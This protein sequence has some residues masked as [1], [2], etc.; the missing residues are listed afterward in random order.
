MPITKDAATTIEGYPF[1]CGHCGI[2][3]NIPEDEGC[4]PLYNLLDIITDHTS[5]LVYSKETVIE[6]KKIVSFFQEVHA[7]SR[8]FDKPLRIVRSSSANRQ[9]GQVVIPKL[10]L[11]V[12]QEMAKAL[13]EGNVNATA[14]LLESLDVEKKNPTLIEELTFFASTKDGVIRDLYTRGSDGKNTSY[15]VYRVCPFCGK[16]L[17]SR[18]GAFPEKRIGVVGFPR[19]GKSAIL[20]ATIDSF[21]KTSFGIQLEENESDEQYQGFVKNYLK[22]YQ[23]NISIQKTQQ[24]ERLSYLFTLTVHG[25]KQNILFVDIA[26]ELLQDEEEKRKSFHEL[27]VNFMRNL[28]CFWLCVDDFQIKQLE[29]PPAQLGLGDESQIATRQLHGGDLSTMLSMLLGNEKKADVPCLALVVKTDFLSPQERKT[30]FKG[31]TATMDTY[32]ICNKVDKFF[33]DEQQLYALRKQ[34]RA[35]IH[36]HNSGMVSC[37]EDHFS[38][39]GYLACSAYGHPVLKYNVAFRSDEKETLIYLKQEFLD[40]SDDEISKAVDIELHRGTQ[41][42]YNTYLEMVKE[43]RFLANQTMTDIELRKADDIE[44][45]KVKAYRLPFSIK[46]GGM[47]RLITANPSIRNETRWISEKTGQAYYISYPASSHSR[48]FCLKA[49]DSIE[50]HEYIVEDHPAPDQAA[51]PL[52]WTLAMLG[53]Y[54]T[55]GEKITTKWKGFSRQEEVSFQVFPPNDQDSKKVICGQMQYHR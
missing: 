5:D 53:C 54:S 52:L 3:L 25:K 29:Q 42:T 17:N 4:I 28:D 21:R 11:R 49:P 39:V 50:E 55:Y 40:T 18:A 1:A 22:R 38:N 23:A 34:I 12:L 19:Q 32:G 48:V 6:K 26:G 24:T 47:L 14:E 13:G 15:S 7:K 37:I 35:F 31:L 46:E 2:L 41:T 27:Y 20:T 10:D 51:M 16:K 44:R 30:I 45:F 8:W 43:K 9:D 36:H 33:L